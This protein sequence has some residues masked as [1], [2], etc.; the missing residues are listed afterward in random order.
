MTMSS[1]TEQDRV[2][3]FPD[4]IDVISRREAVRR[5]SALLGG[6]ALVGGSTLLTACEKERAQPAAGDKVGEFTPDDIAFLDEVAE[7]ILPETKTPGA[8]AANVGAFMAL[9]V[10]DTYDQRERQTFREGMRKLDEASMK[11]NK[12]SFMSATP[13]Q[14]LTLLE[15][16]D[17]EQKTYTDAREAARTP[18][19]QKTAAPKDSAA[20]RGDAY[21]PDQRKEAV[22]GQEAAGA[23]AITAD[24]PTHY[25]RMMKELALL[26]YFT[27][28]IGYTKAMRYTE[29]PG[30]FD[31][32]VPYVAGEPAWASHA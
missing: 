12:A 19:A 26:G 31:P 1:D 21:L 23:A 13:Q 16:L 15:A 25:F 2:R 4:A 9:M 7:T 20:E 8:K 6:I 5:V 30:R 17:R 28:E 27:S 24:A 14:R 22:P 10:T 32:C 11:A 18:A 3:N 29:T